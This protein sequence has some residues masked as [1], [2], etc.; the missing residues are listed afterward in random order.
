MNF[1]GKQGIEMIFESNLQL[2]DILKGKKS[3]HCGNNNKAKFS[4]R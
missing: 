3:I 1:Y 4:D 2:F